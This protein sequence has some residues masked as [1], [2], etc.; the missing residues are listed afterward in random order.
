MMYADL[1]E[2]ID[3]V[4][5]ADLRV[6]IRKEAMGEGDYRDARG[7]VPRQEGDELPEDTIR[8]LRDGET[9]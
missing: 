3:V 4:F 5:S 2:S 1:R 8:R 6:S 9:A 7:V